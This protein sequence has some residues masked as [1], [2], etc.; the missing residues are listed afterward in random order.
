[1]TVQ[2]KAEKRGG[3]QGLS[4]SKMLMLWKTTTKLEKLQVKAK[5]DT[6]QAFKRVNQMIL[7]AP[8]GFL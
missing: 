4:A 5:Q 3:G 2:G 7:M 8:R 1:M 6:R